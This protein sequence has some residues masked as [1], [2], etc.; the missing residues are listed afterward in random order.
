MDIQMEDHLLPI[1]NDLNQKEATKGTYQFSSVGNVQIEDYS[2][3]RQ[4]KQKAKDVETDAVKKRKR[5]E[6]MQNRAMIKTEQAEKKAVEMAHHSKKPGECLKY[7]QVCLD[8][9]LLTTEHGGEILTSLQSAHM[10]YNIQSNL[11]PFSVFWTR[12]VQEYCVGDDMKVQV[13]R[14]KEKEENEM[15]IIWHWGEVIRLIHAEDLTNHIQSLQLTQPGKRVTLVIYGA[16]EYFRHQ[17]TFKR[18]AQIQGKVRKVK[19]SKKEANFV[20]IPIVSE[21]EWESALV[22]LQLFADCSHRLVETPQDL[23]TLIRQFSKAVA[24]APFKREKHKQEQEELEWYAAGESRDCVRVDKNGNGLPRLWQ[25]Q[26]CQ[27]DR[28]GMDTAQ[29]ITS[30]YRSPCALI[31][32]YEK[33]SSEHEGEHMLEDILIRPEVGPLTTSKKVG[34]DISK[35]MYKFFTATDGNTILS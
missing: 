17:K 14:R 12:E 15:L 13:Q 32:A 30:I 24:E 23:G 33:C 2:K 34:P 9:Q 3:K 18:Q 8:K 26:L 22:H 7:I 1:S 28:V 10:Q 20:S 16:E 29:A 11:V 6:R 25:Q 27:F 5:T 31:E 19:T 4:G 21:D 35:K